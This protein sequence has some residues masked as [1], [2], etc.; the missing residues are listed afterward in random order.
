MTY[1]HGR[2]TAAELV[3]AAAD[4]LDHDVREACELTGQVAFHARVA[5][6]VLRMV[7][8]ELLD[9]DGDEALAALRRL[10]Y[11]DEDQLASDIR[12]GTL[13]GR[14]DDVIGCLRE[15]VAYRL[16]IAHPGYESH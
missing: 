12:A 13:D 10:G 5:A 3:A 8:R 7:Q 11:T 1:L 4:F 16:R 14:G 15:V 2:P 9:P 6:N